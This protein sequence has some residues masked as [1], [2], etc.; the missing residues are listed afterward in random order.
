MRYMRAVNYKQLAICLRLLLSEGLEGIVETVI[1]DRGRIEFHVRANAEKS[2]F[3]ELLRQY[4]ML[5]S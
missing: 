3:E 1:T 5:I 2:V 4:E